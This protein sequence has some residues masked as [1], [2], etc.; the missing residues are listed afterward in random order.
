[1]DRDVEKNVRKTDSTTA[2]ST[3]TNISFPENVLRL[4]KTWGVHV[5]HRNTNGVTSYNVI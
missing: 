5:H 4:M 3:L 2:F 1:M